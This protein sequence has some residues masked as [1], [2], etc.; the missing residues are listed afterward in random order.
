M[1]LKV[2]WTNTASE[3]LEDVFD[4]FKIT[5]NLTV[6]RKI[7]KGILKKTNSLS[8][9]PRK[10]QREPLLANRPKEY[11]YLVEGNYKIIYWIDLTTIYVSA[12]FDTRQNPEK[13]NKTE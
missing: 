1:D 4:Y 13:I 3:Q 11:R 6:A 10:G 9:H 8:K 7:V 2:L 12:V 5:T